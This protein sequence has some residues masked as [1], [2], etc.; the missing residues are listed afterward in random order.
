[1]GD[2]KLIRGY[3]GTYDGY[4]GEG[5]IGYTSELDPYDIDDEPIDFDVPDDW[6]QDEIY[7]KKCEGRVMLFNVIGKSL[8]MTLELNETR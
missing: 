2:F 4:H 5:T 7:A 1:M 8:E 6:T 3:P